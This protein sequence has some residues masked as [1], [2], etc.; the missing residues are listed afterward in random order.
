VSV[1]ARR[2]TAL[3]LL[4]LVVLAVA[5]VLLVGRGDGKG[6]APA[7]GA[8]K[9]VPA[10]ALVYV[11]VSTDTG[12]PAVQ[13]AQKLTAKFPSY[14]R[15][16]DSIIRRL[17][18]SGQGGD[19]SGWLGDEASIAL[20]PGSGG[21]AGSLVVVRVRDEKAARDYLAAGRGSE[22]PTSSYRGV[23]LARYGN[24][25]AAFTKGFLVLGQQ[26]SVKA[27]IDLAQGRGSPLAG[28]AD[29]RRSLE[30]LPAD[31]VLDAYATGDGVTRLLSPA[32]GVLGIA[33]LLLSRPG[34]KA[35][36]LALTAEKPGA[37]ITVHTLGTPGSLKLFTPKL[38]SAVPRGSLAYL[39]LRGF[40]RAAARLLAFAGAGQAGRFAKLI[41]DNRSAL[42]G[43]VAV[44]LGASGDRTVLTLIAPAPK[45]ARESVVDGNLVLSTS[46]T[47]VAAVRRGG[48]LAGDEAFRRVVGAPGR[49]V[50]AVGFLDF[51]QLLKLAERTGLNDSKAYQAVRA[52]L[53]Q[54][55]AVG[56]SSSGSGGDTTAEIRFDIP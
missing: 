38:L 49:A 28:A 3:G 30:G 29:Y 18:V 13:R 56:F 20:L 26:D 50:S 19:V 40:D 51:D 27:G 24:V 32:G 12:R 7:A 53:A 48:G 16:R 23:E 44:V 17:S 34:L 4:A 9:L 41:A 39:G 21:T 46:P 47:G 54:L 37:R 52:D 25:V 42:D 10:D 1:V 22:A 43:E 45:G 36:G 31:R 35:T 11:H 5:A 14:A 55:R 6:E 2:R 8:A 15:L 33:G